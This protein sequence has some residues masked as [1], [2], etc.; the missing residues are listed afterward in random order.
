ML[1]SL[2]FFSK[3]N[4][5]FVIGLIVLIRTQVY[6]QQQPQFTQYMFN[7]L[8]INPAYAGVEEALSI[9]AIER[10][11][12]NDVEEAPSTL[13]F[14][15]HSAFL[16]KHVGL[17]LTVISDRIG[18]HRNLTVLSTY[19][20]HIQ[21]DKQS[22]LSM[23]LQ[24]GVDNV[25]SDYQSLLNGSTNDP[26][27]LANV[28]KTF[29]DV[30][31]GVY[32]RSSRF[33]AGVSAPELIPH[34]AS[35]NDTLTI[36]IDKVNFLTYSSYRLTLSE[37]WDAE[38]SVM[39]KYFPGLPLSFDVNANVIYRKVLTLGT[40]YRKTESIDFLMKAQVTQQLQIGYSYDYPIGAAASLANG[41]HEL[42]VNYLFRYVQKKVSS[43]R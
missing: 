37:N 34:S 7:K 30:G 19:A 26:R 14:S 4:L 20:Y 25:R 36:D 43:P 9:T 27:L 16:K 5:I 21:V 15:A 24:V 41:S 28:T 42:M 29:F 32:F 8:V 3:L 39:I 40:S 13:T 18:V 6:A 1:Q 11:Q 22:F 38:P 35:L 2:P 31:F 12:W 17:G 10:R 23:G 33:Q